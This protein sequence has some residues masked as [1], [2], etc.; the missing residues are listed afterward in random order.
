MAVDYTENVLQAIEIIADKKLRDTSFDKTIQATVV[1]ASKAKDG[2]YTVFNG[3]TNFIAYSSETGYKKNDSVMVTIPEGNYD[4]QKIIISKSVKNDKGDDS[5]LIYHS[6]LNNFIN[7]SNNV[8]TEDTSI[9]LLANKT[10]SWD[11]TE[12]NFLNSLKD[13]NK[14]K[15]IFIAQQ[16]IEANAGYTHIGLRAD[17][18]TTLGVYDVISGNYGL[19]LVVEFAQDINEIQEDSNRDNID[20]KKAKVFLLDSNSFFGNIY[21]SSIG[22]TQEILLD[23]SEYASNP[24]IRITLYP[25]QRNNFKTINNENVNDKY[26]TNEPDNIFIKNCYIGLGIISD[27]FVADRA[28]LYTINTN[29]YSSTDSE[30]NITLSWLHKDSEQNI[31]TA[32]YEDNFPEEYEINWYRYTLGKPKPDNFVGAHWE[33]YQNG[34]DWLS[35]LKNKMTRIFIPRQNYQREMVKVVISKNNVKIAETPI[36]ELTNQQ[37]V[38]DP[39]TA[40]LLRKQAGA[41]AI[42]IRDDGEQ[43]N[44][45]VYNKTGHLMDSADKTRTLQAV[46]D[47]NQSII[48]YKNPLDLEGCT[49]ITWRFPLEGMI[50]PIIDMDDGKLIEINQEFLENNN[51]IS[52]SNITIELEESNSVKMIT[53]SSSKKESLSIDS[54]LTSIKYKLKSNLLH[55]GTRSYVYLQIVKNNVIYTASTAMLFST[56]GTSGSGYTISIEWN[57]DINYPVFNVAKENEQL[58]GR[59]ILRDSNQ[60]IVSLESTNQYVGTWHLLSNSSEGKNYF[61]DSPV[62][63]GDQITIEKNNNAL[64]DN[65]TMNQLY[66]LKIVLENFGDYK[67]TAYFPVAL[68]YEENGIKIQSYEGPTTIRYASDGTIDFYNGICKLNCSG[69][70]FISLGYSWKTIS[71]SLTI[72]NS[73]FP[74]FDQDENKILPCPIYY[75]DTETALFGIQYRRKRFGASDTPLWTQPIYIYRDNYPSTTLNEWDGKDIKLNSEEGIIIAH[76]FAAGKKDKDNTFS[77]VVLG[78]WSL[79]DSEGALTKNT[80]IYGFYQNKMS[81]A[82]KDNGTAFIGSD[83][84]G[85]INFDGNEGTIESADFSL[86]EQTGFQ[87]DLTNEALYLFGNKNSLNLDSVYSITLNSSPKEKN[88]PIF[89]IGRML[90]INTEINNMVDSLKEEYKISINNVKTSYMEIYNKIKEYKIFYND[91]K[92]L[93]EGE[94]C[95]KLEKQGNNFI[96]F[97]DYITNLEKINILDEEQIQLPSII[98]DLYKFGTSEDYYSSQSLEEDY[99]SYSFNDTEGQIWKNLQE[100]NPRQKTTPITFL[101]DTCMM[102]II[103]FY[104]KEIY[105]RYK[106]KDT[107]NDKSSFIDEIK[108]TY[109]NLVNQYNFPGQTVGAAKKEVI[110]TEVLDHQSSPLQKGWYF[111]EIIFGEKNQNN[112][113]TLWG[114]PVKDTLGNN[115]LYYQT[116]PIALY[117]GREKITG[118]TG[119]QLNNNNNKRIFL[120]VDNLSSKTGLRSVGNFR[121]FT[122]LFSEEA[123]QLDFKGDNNKGSFYWIPDEVNFKKGFCALRSFLYQEYLSLQEFL[124]AKLPLLNLNIANVESVINK[125]NDLKKEGSKLTNNNIYSY[126]YSY[127]IIG[128]GKSISYDDINLLLL[129]T[130]DIFESSSFDQPQSE[131]QFISS[132]WENNLI[133]I[134][135]TG[136]YLTSMHYRP[137]VL[138]MNENLLPTDNQMPSSVYI[139]NTYGMKGFIIDLT[140]DKIVLGNN[141]AIVGYQ[142]GSWYNDP[143]PLREFSISTGADFGLLDS[144]GVE[145]IYDN[146]NFIVAKQNRKIVFKVDWFGNI[147]C[148]GN[149]TC[150]ELEQ[151]TNP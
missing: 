49:S 135:P 117:P 73:I 93:D 132:D 48:N 141:S 90:N 64:L 52:D 11:I 148:S 116:S 127:A 70:R 88:T 125:I 100:T 37:K 143:Q 61:L 46:Y 9:S 118:L 79:T 119:F 86:E 30:K 78:D 102:D 140:N 41:L 138:N 25:Y 95:L 21:N 14:N 85:R 20:L 129:K 107:L 32:I 103:D 104:I 44:Y 137:T 139:G 142:S 17:F 76:G 94:I 8:I 121:P 144:N 12:D 60:Q 34:E 96:S 120:Q 128:N 114:K 23:I 27:S 150:K 43:G 109:S 35:N 59:I 51:S 136:G 80:G 42:K 22:H 50:I 18:S 16:D 89:Q 62:I 68:K 29:I 115:I 122:I 130:E 147:T 7:V 74:K 6:P 131:I 151:K 5:P 31:A 77:G 110:P 3:G 101:T 26:S 123:T 87:I 97:K 39:N 67:L 71:N 38:P 145:F 84:A 13:S 92:K 54:H 106:T 58:T 98:F 40:E 134:S 36:L 24:I 146:K 69:P 124:F 15:P 82:F 83:A 81:Y 108:N 65:T 55:P 149:I 111:L 112:S 47:E 63:T 57:N 105:Q 1:D 99:K 45:Y 19:A 113:L 66:I 53:I 28:Q 91:L 2:I 4:N 10:C 33:K 72:E 75:S 133:S 126:N 56:F